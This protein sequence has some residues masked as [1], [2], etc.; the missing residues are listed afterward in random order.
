MSTVAKKERVS[1]FGTA[2]RTRIELW[3]AVIF[4]AL[5]FV[6]GVTIGVLAEQREQPVVG[7]A[8]AGQVDTG[9]LPV[10]PPLTEEQLQQGLPSGHPDIAG[11][12]DGSDGGKG[13]QDEGG[14]GRGADATSQTSE[15]GTP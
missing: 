9:G 3:I 15:Q 8:P 5:A 7:V 6:G 11:T 4:M 12:T 13:S 14:G 2:M 1:G 10:A